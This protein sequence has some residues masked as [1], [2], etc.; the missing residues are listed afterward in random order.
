RGIAVDSAAGKLYWTYI[1]PNIDGL[2]AGMIKRSN[3]DGSG[4]ETVVSGLFSPYDVAL[5]G[6]GK[7]LYWTDMEPVRRID[8]GIIQRAALDGAK[9]E[10]LVTRLVNPRGLAVDAMSRFDYEPGDA[11]QDG[12]VDILDVGLIQTK[13]GLVKGAT[14]ADGDFDG[15]GT[16]DIF[17]VAAMQ[18]N[19]GHGVESSPVPE[20]STL[21]LVMVGVLGILIGWWR[22]Q[23]AA[24]VDSER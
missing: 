19:Y 10:T 23:K 5:D 24:Y 4:A 11:D 21:L 22:Q 15:N 1:D 13:Y 12:D 16:V 9:V 20:P 7:S 2:F 8:N 17:D 3:I 6:I 14:W 18:V